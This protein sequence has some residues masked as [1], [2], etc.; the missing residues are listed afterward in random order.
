MIEPGKKNISLSTKKIILIESFV[1]PNK[2]KRKDSE[3]PNALLFFYVLQIRSRP[4][5][6][7]KVLVKE[8]DVFNRIQ[9]NKRNS[10]KQGRKLNEQENVTWTNLFSRLQH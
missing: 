6:E 4:H 8:T 9:K 7:F 2:N 5:N 3:I 1:I 10:E